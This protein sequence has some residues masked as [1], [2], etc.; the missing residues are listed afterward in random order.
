LGKKVD[1]VVGT[2][3]GTYA[4]CS[5]FSILFSN[6]RVALYFIIGQGFWIL[7]SSLFFDIK[8]IFKYNII[9]ERNGLSKYG[10]FALI[11]TVLEEANGN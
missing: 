1:E 2:G 7:N 4:A 6:L 9:I 8:H 11:T 10:W 3:S 5:A